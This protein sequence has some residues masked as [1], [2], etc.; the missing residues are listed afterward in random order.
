MYFHEEIVIDPISGTF[1]D[2]SKSLVTKIVF[3]PKKLF[4]HL[5]L[6]GSF[7]FTSTSSIILLYTSIVYIRDSPIWKGGVGDLFLFDCLHN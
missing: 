4:I 5:M 3:L 1:L 2:L 7:L 6:P